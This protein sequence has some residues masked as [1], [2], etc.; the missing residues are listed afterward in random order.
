MEKRF[1][2]FTIL[3]LN[4]IN[5]ESR[6]FSIKTIKNTDPV[7]LLKAGVQASINSKGMSGLADIETALVYSGG[8]Q[9][10]NATIIELAQGHSNLD[11]KI[12]QLFSNFFLFYCIKSKTSLL[13]V[14]AALNGV[15]F[16]YP[17][18]LPK[19]EINARNQQGQTPAMVAAV[20][21]STE[22]LQFLIKSRASVGSEIIDKTGTNTFM[23]AASMGR[24]DALVL[25]KPYYNRESL[26]AKNESGYTALMLAALYGSLDTI[27]LL[28]SDYKVDVSIKDNND[29]T[30]LDLFN[31]SSS[32]KYR[33][34]RIGSG[35]W[36]EVPG[37][38]KIRDE[39]I[40]LLSSV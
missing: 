7:A 35:P 9:E 16:Q 21:K 39:I 25:L 29:Q 8:S 15:F 36:K 28:V 31:N 19:A 20:E 37:W 2:I 13:E 12:K 32:E 26:N 30:A 18:I 33:Y 38:K 14:K 22:M 10:V 40:K 3:S 23:F 27:R 11:S 4:F 5:I 6:S 17:N 34:T 24:K 1:L